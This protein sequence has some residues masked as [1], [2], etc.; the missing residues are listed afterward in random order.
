MLHD[1]A[2]VCAFIAV[3]RGKCHHFSQ[4]PP[5]VWVQREH[6]PAPLSALRLCRPGYL[7]KEMGAQQAKANEAI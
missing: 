7:G 2:L 6:A 4:N 3:P 1:L 5:G